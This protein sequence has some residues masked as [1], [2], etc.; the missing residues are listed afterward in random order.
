MEEI[1]PQTTV[2]SSF[3]GSQINISNLG[4]IKWHH[5][6]I[7]DQAPWI[8][9]FLHPQY[10]V[11]TLWLKMTF[12]FPIIKV[13]VH[14]QKGENEWNSRLPLFKETSWNFLASHL[15][16][17]HKPELRDMVTSNYEGG[18]EMQ[19]FFQGVVYLS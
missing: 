19:S 12:L 1:L 15:L 5:R 11:S 18:W 6:T 13:P 16:L 17:Y 2:D 10:V 7:R 3:F 14:Q 8:L 9:L 4:L